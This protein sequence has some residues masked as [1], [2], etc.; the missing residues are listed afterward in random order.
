MHYLLVAS[1]L[2]CLCACIRYN[3]KVVLVTVLD[4]YKT[5]YNDLS[6]NH[7]KYSIAR[8]SKHRSP[9]TKR[10]TTTILFSF[11]LCKN[12]HWPSKRFTIMNK[13]FILCTSISLSTNVILTRENCYAQTTLYTVHILILS[14]IKCV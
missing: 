12:S 10:F 9:E 4:I 1:T 6:S 13:M 14:I 7:F 11:M 2:F 8:T 5:K 3:R